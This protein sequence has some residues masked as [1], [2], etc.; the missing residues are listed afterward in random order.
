MAEQRAVAET[1]TGFGTPH[2]GTQSAREDAYFDRCRHSG[3][4]KCRG[5]KDDDFC[6]LNRLNELNQ[7]MVGVYHHCFLSIDH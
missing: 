5:Q 3:H 7:L 2:A 1:K 6:G 4:C